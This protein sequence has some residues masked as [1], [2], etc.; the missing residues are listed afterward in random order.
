MVKRATNVAF[1]VCVYVPLTRLTIYVHV[2][3]KNGVFYMHA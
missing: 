2:K 3:D 1:Y